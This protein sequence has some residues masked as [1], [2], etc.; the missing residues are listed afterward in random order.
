MDLVFPTV[1]GSSDQKYA[2]GPEAS[3]TIMAIITIIMSG[4]VH[5]VTSLLMLLW[6]VS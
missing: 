4:P 2:W 5:G 1:M 6:F 3:G